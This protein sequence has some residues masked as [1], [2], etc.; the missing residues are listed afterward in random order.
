MEKKYFDDFDAFFELF[1][2]VQSSHLVVNIPANI[3]QESIC[4]H[5][6][7]ISIFPLN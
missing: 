6:N 2:G 4:V 3:G 7:N 1:L 5:V